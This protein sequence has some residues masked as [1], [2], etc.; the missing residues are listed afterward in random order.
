MSLTRNSLSS[1]WSRSLANPRGY[2]GDPNYEAG[3]AKTFL[4][5][6][7]N[8][9]KININ[10]I[11]Y[12][13]PVVNQ[14]I[15]NF[16]EVTGVFPIIKEGVAWMQYELGTCFSTNQRI[17]CDINENAT[18]LRT[19]TEFYYDMGKGVIAYKPNQ[20]IVVEGN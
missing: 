18:L 4:S 17:G 7:N 2:A 12:F 10:S 14:K 9:D 3:K 8:H 13:A 5:L 19:T 20:K 16:Y 11:K 6:W 1:D 15:S